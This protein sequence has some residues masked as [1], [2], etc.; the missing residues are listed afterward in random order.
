M[1]KFE[2]K[3]NGRF[4]YIE[5]KKDLFD[6]LVIHITRGGRNHS[7]NYLIYCDNPCSC[8]SQIDR[9]KK[10]RLRRGYTLTN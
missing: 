5:V 10:I 8:R 3:S 6:E 1:I 7:V 2:N 4:Y 9:I